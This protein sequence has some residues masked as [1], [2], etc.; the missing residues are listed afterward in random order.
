M[1]K[2]INSQSHRPLPALTHGCA[3]EPESPKVSGEMKITYY[4][5]I[6]PPHVK[7]LLAFPL[8]SGK[9]LTVSCVK[10]DLDLQAQV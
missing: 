10:T 6:H 9:G 7:A 1:F 5:T 3:I 8:E 4:W 2:L